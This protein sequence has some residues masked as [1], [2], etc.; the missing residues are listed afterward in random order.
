VL[1]SRARPGD[2]LGS[3][4]LSSWDVMPM[5]RGL[6]ASVTQ[7]RW[8]S[9]APPVVL[10]RLSRAQRPKLVGVPFVRADRNLY[11]RSPRTGGGSL[12]GRG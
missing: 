9:L 5:S 1:A 12:Q 2:W 11:P 10:W 6:G 3:L 8:V 7:R 4:P